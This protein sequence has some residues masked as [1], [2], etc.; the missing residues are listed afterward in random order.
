MA[1]GTVPV[2]DL[3]E[4]QGRRLHQFLAKRV[5]PYSPYY[6]RLFDE[7]DINPDSIRRLEDLRRIPFTTKADIVPSK[8]NPDRYRDIV[9]QPSPKQLREDLTLT[10]KIALWAK[11]KIFVRSIQDQLLDEYLPIHLTF[12]TGRTSLPTPFVYTAR[13]M[14]LL[15]EAGRRLFSLV[16]LERTHDRGLNAM[17]FAP[18]L[19]F[20]Q[21]QQ[22]AAAVGLLVLHS[23]GG[24]VIGS[25]ALLR[26]G[27]R[28]APTFLV[29]TPGYIMHLAHLAEELGIRIT[30]V[31]KII[32]GAERVGPEYKAKLRGQMAKIGSP[33]VQIHNVYGFTEAKRAWMETA[34]AADSRFATYPDMEI[35]E[36]VDPDSGEP[37]PEGESG[38]VVY[39]QISGA[40]S[41]V[42]RYRTGDR[43]REGLVYDRCPHTGLILPLL[44]TGLYRVSEIKKVKGTLVDFNEMFAFFNG[45]AE[46]LDWQLV[47]HKPA[48]QEHGRDHITLRVSLCDAIEPAAFERTIRQDFRA[49]TEI[50]LDQVE[51][52]DRTDLSE[53]LG[54]DTQPKETRF[55]DERPAS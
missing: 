16:G 13:D 19:A 35:F 8:D 6:R 10:E 55:V 27:E 22:A 17:P 24:R 38:E 33:N 7:H 45:R 52:Y 44:G 47:L 34:D 3:K 51:Y 30:K 37:V 18:H 48:G 42:L 14:Q 54:L 29:G 4:R 25:E 26:L 31:R 32:L 53:L 23:G 21:V 11:S 2:A 41:V 40:G 46:L 36:I 15:K 20:W 12:T 1:W 28:T 39:T 50:G 49:L 9:L 43:V 5:Y